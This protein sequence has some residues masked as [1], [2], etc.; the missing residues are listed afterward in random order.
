MEILMRAVAS[1][2]SEDIL[3]CWGAGAGQKE[4]EDT[5]AWR[6]AGNGQRSIRRYPQTLGG[7]RASRGG[8]GGR[9][10]AIEERRITPPA[11]DP[12]AGGGQRGVPAHRSPA[13]GGQ[14]ESEDT[15]VVR[16]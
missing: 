2:E 16:N 10:L 15:R 12:C 11:S 7:E 3:T 13:R 1:E 8:W 6:G 4:S 14:R 5:L 9:A